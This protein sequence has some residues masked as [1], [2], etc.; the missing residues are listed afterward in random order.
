MR[1]RPLLALVL[2]AA[3]A[4]GCARFLPWRSP[5]GITGWQPTAPPT[6]SLHEKAAAYQ[7]RIASVHAM[8]DGVIRYRVH[9][10]QGRDEYG[11]LPDGPFFAGLYLAGQAL[12][13]AATGDP[14]AR[15]EVEQA[16]DGMA[17]LMAVTGEPGLLAR[18]VGRGPS[19][20]GTEWVP[21]KARPDYW[22][23]ADVSK[24]QLAGYACGLGVAL[25]VLPDPAVRARIAALAGPLARHLDAHDYRIVDHDGER[26]TYGDLRPRLFGV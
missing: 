4:G 11:D 7:D 13:L 14:A 26:T 5:E 1:A 21:S 20:R 18:F 12:R 19:P 8:P 23:R 25:A 6:L 24:D 16:L 3:S 22:W 10:S 9:A 2:L 15:R 17:L